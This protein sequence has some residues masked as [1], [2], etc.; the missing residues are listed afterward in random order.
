MEEVDGEALLLRNV[1]PDDGVEDMT[2]L[3]YLHEPAL[4]ANLRQRFSRDRVYTYTGKICIAVNP[5]N[6]QVSHHF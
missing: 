3:N 2:K 1:L 5:F 6:W 4:L